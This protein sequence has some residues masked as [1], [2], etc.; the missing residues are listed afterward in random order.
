AVDMMDRRQPT[1]KE[2]EDYAEYYPQQETYQT[3]DVSAQSAAQL[4]QHM[5]GVSP[6]GGS[7]APTPPRSPALDASLTTPAP[8][9]PE[10]PPSP[11]PA[12]PVRR[13]EAR[14][15]PLAAHWPAIPDPDWQLVAL[16]AEE[17]VE[18]SSEALGPAPA[19]ALDGG[20]RG[21][22]PQVETPVA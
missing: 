1:D 15:A 4:L 9:A 3:A 22:S 19:S 7:Q 21:L 17:D 13:T 8:S 10:T 5:L 20:T 18:S 12:A 16:A 6:Q 2:T 11:A 14:P